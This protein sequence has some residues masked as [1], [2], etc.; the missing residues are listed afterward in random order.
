MAVFGAPLSDDLCSKKAVKAALAIHE[1]LENGLMNETDLDQAAIRIWRT[2]F[3]MGLFE[4][5]NPWSDL[6][7]ETLDSEANQEASFQAAA[8]SLTLLQNKESLLPL[9]NP[10]IGLIIDTC[11]PTKAPPALI[12]HHALSNL[13]TFR[14]VCFMVSV[15][16]E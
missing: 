12:T 5:E 3:K 10:G 1:S 14:Y 6:G 13:H 9:H 11:M 8:Q 15:W 7:W 16:T 4:P 2:A